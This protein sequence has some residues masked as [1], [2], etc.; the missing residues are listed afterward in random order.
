MIMERFAFHFR[1]WFLLGI[2][3]FIL[4]EKI[5]FYR[6]TNKIKHADVQVVGQKAFMTWRS[7]TE[8]IA[9]HIVLIAQ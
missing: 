8:C 7:I 2:K 4:K 5:N 1:Q 6:Y 3:S 9:K